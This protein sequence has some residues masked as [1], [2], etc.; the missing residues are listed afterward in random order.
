MGKINIIKGKSQNPSTHLG[1]N[2]MDQE[3]SDFHISKPAQEVGRTYKGEP[4]T[5]YVS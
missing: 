2:L 3:E 5:F 1:A 4:R